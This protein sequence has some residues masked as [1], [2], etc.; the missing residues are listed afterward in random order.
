ME[1]GLKLCREVLKYSYDLHWLPSS[2]CRK[3]SILLFVCSGMKALSEIDSSLCC[4]NCH[5]LVFT[6]F[7]HL[8]K[9]YVLPSFSRVADAFVKFDLWRRISKNLIFH[10]GPCLPSPLKCCVPCVLSY[11]LVLHLL[12][13]C[14]FTEINNFLWYHCLF[15]MWNQTLTCYFTHHNVNHTIIFS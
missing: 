10:A 7:Y 6:E 2:Q 13:I 12:V 9:P 14:N 4:F 1:I 5:R 8:L 3:V 15:P 11:H